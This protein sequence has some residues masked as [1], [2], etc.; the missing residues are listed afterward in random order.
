MRKYTLEMKKTMKS[1]KNKWE[2]NH[3]PGSEDALHK[4]TDSFPFNG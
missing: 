3:T 1:F 4:N 2:N